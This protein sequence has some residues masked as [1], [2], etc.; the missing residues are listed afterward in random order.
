[1]KTFDLSLY[2][3]TD[4]SLSLGRPLKYIVEEAVKGGVTMVQLREK[5]CSSK[6]FHELAVQLKQ[7]LQPYGVPLIINDRLDIALACNADG[8]HIGQND[9]PYVIARKLLG[10][11][12]IIGLSVEN[13]Q[14]VVEANQCDV[15]Y[16]GISPVFST[17]TKTDAAQA[18]GLPGVREITEISKHPS[19]GIGGINE[20]NAKEIIRA[21]ADGISV[22]SAIMS[23]PDPK[24]AAFRLSEI[25]N[26]T[27]QQ[28]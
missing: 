26:Q 21:G 7:C 25:I 23:A 10:K 3:V 13:R 28:P 22:V 15:D 1:M 6:E 19:V 14:D 27:K 12:K 16:I 8:L 11:D 20:S 9:I 17:P 4:R 24:C 2:L 5:T 18:L